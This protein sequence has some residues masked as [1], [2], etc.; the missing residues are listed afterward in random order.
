MGT[1]IKQ[2]LPGMKAK[3]LTNAH[4]AILHESFIA[5]A[6]KRAKGICTGGVFWTS[7]IALT[8]IHLCRELITSGYFKQI[9]PG[10]KVILLTNAHTAILHESFI[11]SAYERA[12]GVCT[13]RVVWTGSIDLTFIHICRELV[14][15]GYIRQILPGMKVKLLTNAHTAILHES[16]IASAYERAKGICTGGLFWTG[17]IDLTLIHICGD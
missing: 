2:I 13:G 6:Y 10:M 8:F 9:L 15:S 1:L 12:K 5:S 4:T 7:S 16:F 14:T 3:F 17:S 11:A